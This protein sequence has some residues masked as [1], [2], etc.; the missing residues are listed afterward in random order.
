MIL[1]MCLYICWMTLRKVA[2]IFAVLLWSRVNPQQVPV[3]KIVAPPGSNVT[4]SCSFPVKLN[5]VLESL[6]INWQCGD[7]VVHSFYHLID[8]L[9]KQNEVYKGRTSLFNDQLQSG[10]A[11]LML[12]DIQ[13]EHDGDY[14]CSV[15]CNNGPYE[16][17]VKLLVAAPYDEP[18][19]AVQYFCKTITVSLSSSHGFPEPDVTWFTPIGDEVKTLTLDSRG[20]YRLQSNITLSLNSTVTVRVEMSLDV[21]SQKFSRALTLHP[22]PECCKEESPRC[23][24]GFCISLV[25]FISVVIIFLF[26]PLSQES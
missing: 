3:E 25:L 18:E 17:K 15:T 13:P 24:I 7:K 22:Q 16:Q 4:L 10:N 26:T 19:I 12:N 1:S 2:V 11:T 6:V 23:M 21:L 5:M 20:R 9:D 8:Q 14:K